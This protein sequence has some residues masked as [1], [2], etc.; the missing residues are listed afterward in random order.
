M[1]TGFPFAFGQ[2]QGAWYGTGDPMDAVNT[3]ASGVGMCNPGIVTNSSGMIYNN[4]NFQ[5]GLQ[6][7]GIDN[8]TSTFLLGS[9][10]SKPATTS[11]LVTGSSLIYNG[12]TLAGGDVLFGDNTIGKANMH[13]NSVAGMLEFR[14][15]TTVQAYVD[16]DGSIVAGAG[17]LKLNSSGILFTSGL[18]PGPN[19]VTWFDTGYANYIGYIWGSAASI[20]LLGYV[21]S[22][23]ITAPMANSGQKASQIYLA[24]DGLYGISSLTITATNSP[25]TYTAEFNGS[26][27]VDNALSVAGNATVAGS[28]QVG[29]GSGSAS[30]VINGSAGSARAIFFDTNG[31]VRNA[32]VG[33]NGTAENGANVG[34]NMSI[35]NYDDSG[36][37]LRSVL[38]IYRSSGV[39]YTPTAIAIG[40]GSNVAPGSV[41]SLVIPYITSQTTATDALAGNTPACLVAIN[42]GTTYKLGVRMGGTWRYVAVA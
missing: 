27:T 22:V 9:D 37:F 40:S 28:L 29:S 19:A 36:V 24:A 31:S 21:A 42:N 10:I 20:P 3:Q 25:A 32:I 4:F 41:G 7:M 39:I 11:L 5:N 26:L 23:N 34:S 35:N 38:V 14:G 15:G 1:N 2:N 12:E 18:N 30:E 8:I 33:A 17:A 16:T 13:W 6:T